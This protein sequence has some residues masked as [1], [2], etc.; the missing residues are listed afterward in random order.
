MEP[1]D[2]CSRWLK[3]RTYSYKADDTDEVR[4][5][6]SPSRLEFERTTQGTWRS[7]PSSIPYESFRGVL[8][9]SPYCAPAAQTRPDAGSSSVRS[10]SGARQLNASAAAD[11]GAVVTCELYFVLPADDS[12]GS[13]YDY[14]L[15]TLL[16]SAD[17]TRALAERGGEFAEWWSLMASASNAL[18]LAHRYLAA[19]PQGLEDAAKW[20]ARP[21]ACKAVVTMSETFEVDGPSPPLDFSEKTAIGRRSPNYAQSDARP[22]CSES[23]RS[24]RDSSN[25]GTHSQGSN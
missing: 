18:Q 17:A 14:R 10:T 3:A 23:R 6:F 15:R 5:R 24:A 4:F 2:A 7:T 22:S 16:L 20:A 12:Y 9:G 8:F 25:S 21:G 1:A 19:W 13:S 11:Y